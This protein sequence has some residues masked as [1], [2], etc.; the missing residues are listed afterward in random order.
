VIWFVYILQSEP[1][2][3]LYT[4]MTSDPESRLRKHNGLYKG[5]AKATRSGR[6]WRLVYVEELP[7]KSSALRREAAIK[8]LGHKAK[9]DI[10]E[11]NS[12]SDPEVENR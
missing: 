9:L 12:L 2:G 8:R 3:T 1:K 11:R 4:G 6:P 7:D 10:V 5:G